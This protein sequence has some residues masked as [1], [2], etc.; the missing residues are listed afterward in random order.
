VHLTT[1][2]DST[3]YIDHK[4]R[5]R[6]RLGYAY[7]LGKAMDGGL[8]AHPD[9]ILNG[10]VVAIERL[11]T[12]IG[13]DNTHKRGYTMAKVVEESGIL[14]EME[15]IIRIVE[16]RL[17]ITWEQDDTLTYAAAQLGTAR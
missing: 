8:G 13:I 3:L 4:L 17:H 1:K 2:S 11:R 16:G 10:E 6:L 12:T 14:T 7:T 15:G 9:D 5:H